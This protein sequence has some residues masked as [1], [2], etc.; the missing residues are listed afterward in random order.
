MSTQIPRAPNLAVAEM[1]ALFHIKEFCCGRRKAETI[2]S[3]SKTCG[4]HRRR[5]HDIVARLAQEHP[6]GTTPQGVFWI[7]DEADRRAAQGN[8]LPRALKIL[9]R[10]HKVSK[11][12]ADEIAGQVK[13]ELSDE[14]D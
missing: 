3:L 2:E 6:I 13:M 5:M 9:K 10:Y 4:V 11:L 1:M 8:L 12:S 14:H 7:V